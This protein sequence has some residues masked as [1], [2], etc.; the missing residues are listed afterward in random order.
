MSALRFLT[1]IINAVMPFYITIAA[2][3][4]INVSVLSHKD[5]MCS[6]AQ[7]DFI[8]R[9]KCSGQPLCGSTLVR[10]MYNQVLPPS[11]THIVRSVLKIK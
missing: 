8:H 2:S 5:L 4:P 11:T 7:S 6:I 3:V 9:E 1:A 10:L